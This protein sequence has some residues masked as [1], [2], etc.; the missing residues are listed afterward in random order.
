[1]NA[2]KAPEGFKS[3]EI[4]ANGTS[5]LSWKNLQDPDYNM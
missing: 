3:D 1:M 5:T 4:N 2:C